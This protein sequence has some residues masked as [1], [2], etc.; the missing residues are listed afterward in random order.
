MRRAEND[1]SLETEVDDAPRKRKPPRRYIDSDKDD[2]DKENNVPPRKD[3]G[4]RKN[5]IRKLSESSNKSKNKTLPQVNSDILNAVKETIHVQDKEKEKMRRRQ[6]FEDNIEFRV[7]DNSSQGSERKQRNLQKVRGGQSQSYINEKEKQRKMDHT[8]QKESIT[9]PRKDCETSSFF[10]SIKDKTTSSKI[11]EVSNTFRFNSLMSTSDLTTDAVQD[12]RFSFPPSMRI[13]NVDKGSSCS[14]QNPSPIQTIISGASFEDLSA[15]N[16]E[17][18]QNKT[19]PICYKVGEE[20]TK[21][22]V[23][24]RYASNFKDKGI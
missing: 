20:E 24:P 3:K 2:E 15:S 17:I 12:F 13:D 8:K 19:Q 10:S 4:S 5:K 1:T 11:S 18:D 7:Q 6:P 22:Q 23:E 16:S 14:F 9:V 21:I